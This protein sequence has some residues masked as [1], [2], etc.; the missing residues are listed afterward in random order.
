[1]GI[2]MAGA[3]WAGVEVAKKMTS[4]GKEKNAIN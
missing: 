1:M 4:R 3:G 2:L